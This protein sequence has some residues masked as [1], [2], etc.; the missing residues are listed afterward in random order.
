MPKELDEIA[1]D[2]E[3]AVDEAGE[4]VERAVDAAGEQVKRAVDGAVPALEKSADKAAAL[5]K[6]AVGAGVEHLTLWARMV[7]R[8]WRFLGRMSNPPW[9]LDKLLFWAIAVLLVVVLSVFNHLYHTGV[10]GLPVLEKAGSDFIAAAASLGVVGLFVFTAVSTLFFLFIPTEPFFL[11]ILAVSPSIV[12]PIAAA[13]FGST[14]GSCANY[15]FGK[16]LRLRSIKKKGDEAKL[17]KWGKRAHS[18]WGTAILFL[19]ASLPV[20]EIIALAYGL[21]DYPFKKFTLVTLAA[22]FVK[23]TWVAMAFLLFRISIG[24]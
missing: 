7:E 21:A 1:R 24:G 2:V 19:A 10:L 4:H 18:K 14:V 15:W 5:T 12:L 16:R 22:R 6:S 20:P 11:L 9:T 23:W 17:G 8:G 13:A 3:R